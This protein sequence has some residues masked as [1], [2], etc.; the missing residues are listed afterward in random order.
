MPN[1]TTVRFSGDNLPP[2]RPQPPKRTRHV[3]MLGPNAVAL[4]I[5]NTDE[6]VIIQVPQQI[7]LGRYMPTGSQAITMPQPQVDLTPYDAYNK[8]VSR[9]H[10]TLRRSETGGLSIED[11]MS[12]NGTFLNSARLQAH[13]RKPLSP[14]DHLRLGQLDLEIYFGSEADAARQLAAPRDERKGTDQLRPSTI[15]IQRPTKDALPS[16]A[17]LGVETRPAPGPSAPTS[18]TL[19]STGKLVEAPAQASTGLPTH[20]QAKSLLHPR[21]VSRDTAIL[22]EELIMHLNNQPGAKVKLTLEIE[23]TSP[24]GFDPEFQHMIEENSQLLKLLLSQFTT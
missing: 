6:P 19:P 18:A 23:A 10:A 11:M 3:G 16:T 8:G 17:Q 12:S 1:T 2:E 21:H 20:Y 15:E 22:F 14:G 5:N 24:Q 9:I 4:Y 7:T 13:V